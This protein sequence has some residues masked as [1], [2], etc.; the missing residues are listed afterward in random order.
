MAELINGFTGFAQK[1]AE[2][3]HS[4][5]TETPTDVISPNPRV[6]FDPERLATIPQTERRWAWA[7]IDLNAIVH[8]MQMA[9]AVAKPGVRLMAVVKG[10]AFGHGLIRVAKTAVN[11][12]AEY[13]GIGTVDEG[14]ALRE[15]QLNVPILLLDQPPASAIPLLLGYKIMPSVYTTDFAI[16]YGEMADQCGV[17][18]PYHLAMNTGMNRIGVRYDEAAEFLRQI[19]FHRALQLRGIFTHFATADTGDSLEVERQMRRFVDAL[20]AIHSAGI[21]TGIVHCANTAAAVL[22]PHTQLHMVRWGQG[23]YGLHPTMET[24]RVLNLRPAM[25]VHARISDVRMLPMGEGI[26]LGLSYRGVGSAKACTVPLGYA[27]GLTGTLANRMDVLH[28]GM[29][30]KQVGSICMNHLMF[31]VD[32]RS[33]AGRARSNP[34]PGDEVIIVGRQGDQVITMSDLARA[35]SISATELVCSL[36]AHLPRVYVL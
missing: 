13:L 34:L 20:T 9:R 3:T 1:R 11:A 24:R 6:S 27:D 19:S 25:S 30:C 18:A 2:G 33:R 14:I 21:D 12:G 23:L 32:M 5:A 15:A 36:G 7:E 8:N 28:A 4:L 29:R 31:E 17:E 35:A 16:Q 10:D 26:S 22:F